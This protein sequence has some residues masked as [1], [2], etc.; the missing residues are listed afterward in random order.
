MLDFAKML[1]ASAVMG[2]AVWFTQGALA[3]RLGDSLASRV[4]LVAVPTAVGVVVYFILA[5]LTRI[6][7]IAQIKA[8]VRRR[9]AS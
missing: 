9:K 1:L 3:P 7:T 8:L 6:S 2:A 5:V 4:L